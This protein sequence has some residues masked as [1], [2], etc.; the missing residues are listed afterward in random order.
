M[1][2]YIKSIIFAIICIA[3]LAGCATINTGYRAADTIAFE[4]SFTKDHIKTSLC[5][6]TSFYHI[7]N[8]GAPLT[9]YIE[10]DG[11]AWRS[12]HRLSDDPTPRHPLV[13]SLAA[14]DPSENVAYIAR[15]G[16]LTA[17]GRPDCDPA[18]WSEKRFSREVVSAIDSAIDDLKAK[19]QSKE[20]NIIGYSG[21]AAIA[22]IITAERSDV[23]TLRTI[24]GNL[25]PEAVNRYNKVS[26]IEAPPVPIDFAA[27]I[28]NIPQRHF[29]SS[30]DNVVPV[31]IA[32]S[33]SEK[34]GDQ[35][36]ES[37]TMVT[38]TNHTSGWQKSWPSLIS[39]PLYKQK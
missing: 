30:G 22:V 3:F 5:T 21:G 6:V 37:I 4:H 34:I 38:G 7:N 32:E 2:E 19:S 18:Y 23:K 27:K 13:L 17:S 24:A 10:G 11:T 20:I 26:P 1:P 33:F 36:H 9:V 14:I 35:K 28:A 31:S 16:Q 39:I 25:D 12:R 15:P 29:V 8:P